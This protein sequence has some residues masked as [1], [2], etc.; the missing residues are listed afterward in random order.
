MSRPRPLRARVTAVIKQT[1]AHLLYAFG[2]LGVLI[3]RRLHGRAVVLTYHRVLPDDELERTWSHPAIVVRSGTF[4]RHLEALQRHFDVL[5]LETF[6][7][8]LESGQPFER[9]SCLVTFDD[10]WIDTYTQAWPALRAASMP[11]T[12]FLPVDFIGADRMFWQEQGSALLAVIAARAG[13][14]PAFAERATAA[15]AP[16]GMHRVFGL[17]G[18]ALREA[19]A[20]AMQVRKHDDPGRHRSPLPTLLELAAASTPPVG[21]VDAFM[22]WPQVREMA[23]GG[24]TFGGHGVT[25]RLLDTLPP[26]EADAE[27]G[28][29]RTALERE[30]PGHAI[31]FCYPNG[32]WSPAVAAAVQRQG[33]RV[34]FSTER[35]LAGPDSERFAVRRINIHEDVTSTVPLF[36]ARLAGVL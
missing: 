19:I 30:L 25:H 22:T 27:V 9:P 18:A 16:H 23:A 29:S 15:L 8:R 21:G 34:A 17:M 12:V 14:D 31:A 10:G 32:N 24:I 36:L 6:T 11:A 4:G 2:L 13:Q 7:A 20:E 26:A 33:F 1:M 5:S 35:G 28:G 3:R